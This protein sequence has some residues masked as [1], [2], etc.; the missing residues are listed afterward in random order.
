MGFN[1]QARQTRWDVL[2][3]N[4]KTRLQ[5]LPQ[6]A[7]GQAEFEKLINEDLALFAQQS[8]LTASARDIVVQRRTLAKS[9]NRLRE[10]LAAGLRH[11]FGS[12]SQK[13]VEF[14][15]KPQARKKKKKDPSTNGG[16]P[17]VTPP[18]LPPAA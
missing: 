1:F 7:E 14:G 18:T 12:E 17:P 4:L 10:F 16:E 9:G 13:L 8:Q 6:L 5:D 3:A 11:H 15:V 2:N